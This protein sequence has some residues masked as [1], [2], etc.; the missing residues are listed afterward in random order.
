[1]RFPAVGDH[2]GCCWLEFGRR[3][4]DLPLV[5]VAAVVTTDPDGRLTRTS[6]VCGG[7]HDTPWTVAAAGEV[8]GAAPNA[9]AIAHV[10]AESARACRPVDDARTTAA[11]RRL[12][13]VALV[14]RA[15]AEACAK[16]GRADAA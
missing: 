9:E 11:H 5:G 16:A 1:V 2:A 12:L 6:V 7:V 3:P 10:A 14:R 4:G 8:V 15:L 13:V